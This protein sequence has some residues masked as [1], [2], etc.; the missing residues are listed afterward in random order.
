M[1][2]KGA[3]ARAA[4]RKQ[5]DK[6]KSKRWYDIRAPRNPWS[7][8]VIGETIAEDDSKVLG[9]IYEITQHELDGDFSRMHVKLR[10]RV[11]ETLNRDALTEFIGHEM[12]QDHMRRQ[13]R[14]YRGKMDDVIDVI[15][16][17]GY[18]IRVKPLIISQRRINSSRK[19]A[20]RELTRDVIMQAGGTSTWIDLQKS[21]LDGTMERAIKDA[22]VKIHPIRNVMIRKSEMCQSGV[23]SEDGPTLDEIL[24]EEKISKAAK[25]VQVEVSDEADVLAAAEAGEVISETVKDSKEAKS[26]TDKTEDSAEQAAE[27]APATEGESEE[28]EGKDVEE[29][30]ALETDDTD[31]DSSN[32]DYSSMTVAELKDL[33]REAGK[34]VSGK[35][36]DLISR[37][38]E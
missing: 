11:T 2:S 24:N 21:M 5:R 18:H 23:L 29:P 20:I 22:S 37:L 34:P 9:R 36:A 6:W 27:E 8:Q 25:A 4:A 14:R 3:S 7:Y 30:A 16:V 19:S 33:L 15:T 12:M 17:D 13:V 10:F 35:K 31:D 1:A 32:V 38:N 28:S 26:P